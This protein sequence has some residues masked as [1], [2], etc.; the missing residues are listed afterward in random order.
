MNLARGAGD[1]PTRDQMMDGRR[2]VAID[3]AKQK[4]G[5]GPT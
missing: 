2:L 1:Q 3:P 5:S 4:L